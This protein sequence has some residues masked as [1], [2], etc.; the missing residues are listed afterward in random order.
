MRFSFC[1]FVSLLVLT[2]PAF[3][4]SPENAEAK[5]TTVPFTLDHNRVII[6]IDVPLANGS[7]QRVHAWLDNGNPELW[8]S[9]RVATLMG[10]AVHCGSDTCTAVGPMHSITIGGMEI[11][12]GSLKQAIIPAHSQQSDSDQ[13]QAVMVPGMNAEINIPST[14]LRNFAIIVDF[15]GRHFTIG[16]PGSVKFNGVSTKVLINPDDGRVQVPSK[17]ENKKYDLAFDFGSSISFLSQDIFDKLSAAHPRWPQMTGAVGPANMWGAIDEPKWKLMRVDRLQYG[18]EFLSGTVVARFPAETSE[19]AKRAGK[20]AGSLLG[21]EGLLPYRIGLDYA[22]KLAYFEIGSTFKAPDF[23]VIGLILRPEID[24]R[25]TVIAVADFDGK[26]AVPQGPD[27]VQ[28]GDHLVGVNGIPTAGSTLGQVWSMLR[29]TPDQERKL[30][31]ERNGSQ[32][33]VIANVR[34]FLPE[35]ADASEGKSSKEH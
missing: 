6:D 33:T 18:P 28:A 14:V 10:L 30:T 21:T 2:S 8:M 22:H 26:A 4:Q 5:S 19:V 17:I 34:H 23:D 15:P 12:F 32:F 3:G 31:L 11:P 7:T 9:R 29:G 13:A 35:A 25:F 16:A 1:F 24:G 20:S 27:G